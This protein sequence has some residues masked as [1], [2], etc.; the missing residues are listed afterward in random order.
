MARVLRSIQQDA[1]IGHSRLHAPDPFTSD[2]EEETPVV[3]S[4]DSLSLDYEHELWLQD[5][6]APFHSVKRV[7]ISQLPT[8][9]SEFF[10]DKRRKFEWN[11]TQEDKEIYKRR[12]ILRI[13]AMRHGHTGVPVRVEHF[14]SRRRRSSWMFMLWKDWRSAHLDVEEPETWF[15]PETGAPV[16]GWDTYSDLID[17]CR[18]DLFVW[19]EL[20]LL[21]FPAHLYGLP[22]VEGEVRTDGDTTVTY[23]VTLPVEI[24]AELF[25]YVA[26]CGTTGQWPYLRDQHPDTLPSRPPQRYHGRMLNWN[27]DRSVQWGPLDHVH[28]LFRGDTNTE[29]FAPLEDIHVMPKDEGETYEGRLYHYN[30]G[31]CAYD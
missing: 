30:V 27:V 5:G 19:E 7:D 13:R 16:I 3:D 28:R 10:Q 8:F 22:E 21:R 18:H 20:L 1:E 24:L 17:Y 14:G 12:S 31:T 9:R 26:G 23:F 2:Q 4:D 29:S 11:G 15:H 25:R 6:H